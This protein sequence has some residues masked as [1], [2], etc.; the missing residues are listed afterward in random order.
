METL[1]KAVSKH[2]DIISIS[3][4]WRWTPDDERMDNWKQWFGRDCPVVCDSCSRGKVC[5]QR[6]ED[7]INRVVVFAGIVLPYPSRSRMD[8]IDVQQ[9]INAVDVQLTINILLGLG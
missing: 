2:L 7:P 8:A 1:F 3:W 4:Y 9:A 5:S 6:K